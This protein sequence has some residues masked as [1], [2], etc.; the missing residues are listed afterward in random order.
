MNATCVNFTT[1]AHCTGTC[2][3]LSDEPENEEL[4][5]D[6]CLL[7]GSAAWLPCF[8]QPSLV[9]EW[10][11]VEVVPW[12]YYLLQGRATLGYAR[13]LLSRPQLLQQ[14]VT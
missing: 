8:S 9:R 12:W 2:T 6:C 3:C 5:Q 11:H 1:R 7:L 10:G 14:P 13:L 4:R